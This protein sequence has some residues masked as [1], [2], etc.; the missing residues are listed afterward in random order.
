MRIS[1]KKIQDFTRSIWVRDLFLLIILCSVLYANS[2]NGSFVA[3]DQSYVVENTHVRDG[4][5]FL[6][7]FGEGFCEASL[8]GPGCPYYRPLVTLSY[9]LDYLLWG[10]NPFGFHLTNVVIHIL[11][12]LLFYVVIRVVFQQRLV[13]WVA[14]L[15]FAVHPI[16]V[17]SVAVVFNRTDSPITFFFLLSFLGFYFYLKR[18]RWSLYSYIL[19]LMAFVLALLTKEMGITIPVIL[20]AYDLIWVRPWRGVKD[21]IGRWPSYLPFVMV[22]ILYFGVRWM[23]L[24]AGTKPI[25]MG[26]T[27]LIE[28]L[29]IAPILFQQYLALIIFPYPLVII[30]PEVVVSGL[31]DPEFLISLL[32]LVLFGI[33]LLWGW[34]KYPG[35]VF[36]GFFLLISFL[37]VLNIIQMFSPSVAERHAYFPSLGFC[38]GIGFLGSYLIR[39]DILERSLWWNRGCLLIFGSIL[40]VFSF[41]VLDRS[42]VWHD[43]VL[44]WE[45][46]FRKRSPEFPIGHMALATAYYQRGDLEKAEREFKLALQYTKQR[47]PHEYLGLIFQR[48]GKNQQAISHFRKAILKG[49]KTPMIFYNL[50]VIL[51]L[52]EKGNLSEVESLLWKAILLNPNYSKAYLGLAKIHMDQK[53][54][55]QAIKAFKEVVRITPQDYLSHFDLATLLEQEGFLEDA[56]RHYEIF[57]EQAPVSAASKVK[58]T[59]AKRRL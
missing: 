37:P 11:V 53:N 1:L 4:G 8:R 3:D 30:H 21:L 27:S 54:S 5:G 51:Y 39:R 49:T 45:D 40:M 31:F 41:M 28:R 56:A 19:S 24:G 43:E 55:E 6:S 32:L 7:Y 22:W 50:S 2:L 35:I 18:S 23:V 42:K 17:E 25:F 48:Q 36:S 46:V 20:L 59:R 38:L 34:K 13:A 10:M 57:L 15:L 52:Y 9:R 29:L 58:R 12:V 14:S 44:L 16:H 26:E 33:F 47:Y